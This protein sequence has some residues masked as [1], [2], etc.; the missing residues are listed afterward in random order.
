VKVVTFWALG[1]ATFIEYPTFPMMVVA[2][3]I[4]SVEEARADCV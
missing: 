2:E 1:T 3:L 4:V